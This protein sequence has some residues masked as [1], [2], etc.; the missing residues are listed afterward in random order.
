MPLSSPQPHEDLAFE[1]GFHLPS[2]PWRPRDDFWRSLQLV[3]TPSCLIQPS[4]LYQALTLLSPFHRASNPETSWSTSIRRL[5]AY[6]GT[7]SQIHKPIYWLFCTA[8]SGP[9]AWFTRLVSSN[10]KWLRCPGAADE[11]S[12][13]SLESLLGG[14]RGSSPRQSNEWAPLVSVQGVGEA[15]A[16]TDGNQVT[17]E[18]LFGMRGEICCLCVLVWSRRC[19][20]L[21][22]VLRAL[23]TQPCSLRMHL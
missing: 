22:S 7:S 18:P 2:T 5:F 11:D 3:A 10:L 20:I 19:P 15:L 12:K 9:R 23:I 21:L 16:S 1:W 6:I 14:L 17:L 13:S 4:R 8:C